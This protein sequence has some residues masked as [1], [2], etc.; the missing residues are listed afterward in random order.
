MGFD[1]SSF[2]CP[3]S[4]DKFTSPV[5]T[6]CGHTF[7]YPHLCQHLEISYTCP[8]DRNALT[9]EN[10][11]NNYLVN[12]LTSILDD[13]VP[14]FV[15]SHEQAPIFPH[16]CF[17]SRNPLTSP[18]TLP[19]YDRHQIIM[20]EA[21]LVKFTLSRMK[22]QQQ[23]IPEALS[24]GISSLEKLKDGGGKVSCPCCNKEYDPVDETTR[25]TELL[26][27]TQEK[28]SQEYPVFLEKIK[29]FNTNLQEKVVSQR[30]DDR[31]II[32]QALTCPISKQL[33]SNP[34]VASCGHTFD[35]SSLLSGL[36]CPHDETLLNVEDTVPN[37]TVKNFLLTMNESFSSLFCNRDDAR[38]INGCWLFLKKDSTGRRV[39]QIT[40]QLGFYEQKPRS[41]PLFIT[42]KGRNFGYYN[43]LSD[44]QSEEISVLQRANRRMY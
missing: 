33:L 42:S 37:F 40:K 10:L 39:E 18:V 1:I 25:N 19:C 26:S 21:S 4:F 9:M 15:S 38:D 20:N 3:I 12:D 31:H 22:H 7:D 5:I 6:P 35:K 24:R 16:R 11:R 13:M 36:K 44:Y 41:I 17:W 29:L 34:F 27:V 28:S 14:I 32:Q 30:L 8:L 2:S 43:N 23:E